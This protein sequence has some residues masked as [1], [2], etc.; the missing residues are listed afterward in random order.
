MLY[1]LGDDY[2]ITTPFNPDALDMSTLPTNMD[3]YAGFNVPGLKPTVE[4]PGSTDKLNI[5]ILPKW[6][7]A[8][9]MIGGVILF[10][11][12]FTGPFFKKGK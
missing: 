5:P 7:H 9:I 8:P 1:Y 10:M 11:R 3:N 12:V 6:S 4:D 2:S